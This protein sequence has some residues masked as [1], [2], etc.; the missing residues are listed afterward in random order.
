VRKSLF[1][2][3][4]R[5]RAAAF[6]IEW[7]DAKGDE[8]QQDQPLILDLLDLFG[9]F[10][11]KS[12]TLAKES[13]AKLNR[14]PR[15]HRRTH[16]GLVLIEMNS[17]GKNLGLVEIQARDPTQHPEETEIPRYILASDFKRSRLPDLHAS[18]GVSGRIDTVQRST[19]SMPRHSW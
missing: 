16:T 5:T 14:Q 18:K 11:N 9:C 12:C 1:L 17:V 8:K 3:E 19:T 2:D 7:R 13:P 15:L 6:V 4:I 10:T